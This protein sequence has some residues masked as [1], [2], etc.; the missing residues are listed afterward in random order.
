M[1]CGVGPRCG[2]DPTL[3]WLWYRPVA[4]AQIGPLAW[5]PPYATGAALK[6]KGKTNKRTY[7]TQNLRNSYSFQVTYEILTKMDHMLGHKA[8]LKSQ[9]C[10][11]Y[12]PIKIKLNISTIEK[13]KI[14]SV[15]KLRNMFLFFIFFFLN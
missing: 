11:M 6:T 7:E 8:S 13:L 12:S 5:D 10:K 15:W 2:W 1:S 3:L 14:P 4:S 9:F